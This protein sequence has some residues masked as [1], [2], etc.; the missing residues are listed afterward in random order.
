[1]HG[2]EFH[3]LC[4]HLVGGLQVMCSLEAGTETGRELLRS[5]PAGL[6]FRDVWGLTV[7]YLANSV[8]S[9]SCGT[10][11]VPCCHHVLPNMVACFL[12]L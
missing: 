6:K 11:L 8:V 7:L 5:T 3:M 4:D 1:M 2:K 9:S 10:V 12:K